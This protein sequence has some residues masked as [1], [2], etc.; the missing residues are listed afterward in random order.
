MPQSFSVRPKTRVSSQRPESRRILVTGAAG[1]IGSYFAEHAHAKY[2]LRLMVQHGEE[3]DAV[4]AYGE[5]VT[6]DLADQRGELGGGEELD[7]G[8][9]AELA[10][11]ADEAAMRL[12]APAMSVSASD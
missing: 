3:A 10:K 9:G 1:N 6:G 8:V 2:Q 12:E 11:S 4:A 5:V 7:A